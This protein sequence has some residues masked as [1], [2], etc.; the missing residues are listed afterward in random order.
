VGVE[1][2]SDVRKV[3]EWSGYG[4]GETVEDKGEVRQ[5]L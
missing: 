1:E 5:T 3:R 2:G 4:T